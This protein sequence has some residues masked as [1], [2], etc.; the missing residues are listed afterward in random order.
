MMKIICLA[1][2][3]SLSVAT[4]ANAQ[5]I[6]EVEQNSLSAAS[7][8]EAFALSVEEHAIND[9][10]LPNINL[11]AVDALRKS[12]ITSIQGGFADRRDFYDS[13]E[14]FFA[15]HWSVTPGFES[16][17]EN[18]LISE[19]GQPSSTHSDGRKLWIGA[20]MSVVYDVYPNGA[21]V[22]FFAVD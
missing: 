17:V 21:K 22:S 3:I 5:A 15:T 4:Y 16:D 13:N 1:A 7:F 8:D 2:A 6:E 11:A 20:T 14:Q 18:L 12:D 19:Y 9:S 10:G